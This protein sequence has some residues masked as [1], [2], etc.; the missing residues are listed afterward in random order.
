M[1]RIM[2]PILPTLSILGYWGIIFG[3]FGGP[4]TFGTW[5]VECAVA[6]EQPHRA[7]LE[8]FQIVQVDS[9]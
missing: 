1:A 2:D 5:D 8:P 9:D 6:S 7:T 3:S 4:G